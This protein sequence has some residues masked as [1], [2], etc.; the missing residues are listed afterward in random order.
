M[1][2]DPFPYT[3]QVESFTS[4]IFVWLNAHIEFNHYIYGAVS[5]GSDK[6]VSIVKFAY[7]EDYVEFCLT[8][9]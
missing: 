3:C 2:V 1:Y 5:I 7:Q 4:E 9:L 8:W 6:V